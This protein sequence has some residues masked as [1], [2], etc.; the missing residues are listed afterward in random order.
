MKCKMSVD[1]FESEGDA[2]ARKMRN[3]AMRKVG[4]GEMS[5]GYG[6]V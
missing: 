4:E 2:E 6:C 3:D 1:I 5:K